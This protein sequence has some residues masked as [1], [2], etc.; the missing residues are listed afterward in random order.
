M[1]FLLV[2]L[3]CTTYTLHQA[4]QMQGFLLQEDFS[5]WDAS[6]CRSIKVFLP[7]MPQ[8][9]Q[10]IS[11]PNHCIRSVICI[12]YIQVINFILSFANYAPSIPL[13]ITVD[14][15]NMVTCDF[16]IFLHISRCLVNYIYNLRLF[17]HKITD[18]LH[19]FLH[20]VFGCWHSVLDFVSHQ[21]YCTLTLLVTFSFT[22]TTKGKRTICDLVLASRLLFNRWP[23]ML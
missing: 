18:F 14:I 16:Y 11:F 8:S 19:N 20:L 17:K 2:V 22:C 7:L 3:S 1:V 15:F 5:F 13:D 21:L 10:F 9:N 4:H 23:T 6:Y 12:S